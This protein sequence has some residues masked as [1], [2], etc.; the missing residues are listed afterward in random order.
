MNYILDTDMITL[1]SRRESAEAIR[2]DRRIVA[3]GDGDFAVTSVITYEEQMRGW[4][5]LLAG[6]KSGIPEVDVYDRLL[7][8]IEFYRHITVIAYDSTAAGICAEL[9]KQR[10]RIGR[11]DMKIA[12]IALAVGAVIVTRNARD[13]SKVPNLRIEDWSVE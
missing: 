9:Q 8:H 5:A 10:M 3:L 11:M 12:A 13:F 2:I 6:K 7:K 4:M 1:L